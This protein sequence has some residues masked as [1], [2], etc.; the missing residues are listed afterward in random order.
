MSVKFFLAHYFKLMVNG[1]MADL[2]SVVPFRKGNAV[3][4]SYKSIFVRDIKG[5]V[6]GTCYLTLFFVLKEKLINL[7]HSCDFNIN[8]AYFNRE[9]C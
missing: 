8:K 5:R 9:P 2:F 3:M 1:N 6:S 4:E 7:V